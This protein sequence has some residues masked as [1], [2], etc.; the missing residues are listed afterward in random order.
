VLDGGKRRR[1]FLGQRDVVV[2][3]GTNVL[4]RTLVRVR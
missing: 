1:H 3:G 4:N 2:L